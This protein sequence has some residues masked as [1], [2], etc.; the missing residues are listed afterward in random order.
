MRLRASGDGGFGQS[1]KDSNEGSVVGGLW[2]IQA[3]GRSEQSNEVGFTV[4]NRDLNEPRVGLGV[5]HGKDFESM[6]H[7][8]EQW[9]QCW[10][11]MCWAF[12]ELI[13]Q[14]RDELRR[15]E[16]FVCV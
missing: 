8:N 13:R 11:M 3:T 1:I 2:K 7:I 12:E 10:K 9:R 16:F 4:D 5:E 15:V 6:A 14:R